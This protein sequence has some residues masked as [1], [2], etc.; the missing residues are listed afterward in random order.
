MTMFLRER[1]MEEQ[2]QIRAIARGFRIIKMVEQ[3]PTCANRQGSAVAAI[4]I[5]LYM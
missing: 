4:R 3:L 1:S 2:Q 5:T